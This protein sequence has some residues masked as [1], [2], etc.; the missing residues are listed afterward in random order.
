MLHGRVKILVPG[1]TNGLTQST[2][3]FDVF[4]PAFFSLRA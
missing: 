2:P 3:K 1:Y 4:E